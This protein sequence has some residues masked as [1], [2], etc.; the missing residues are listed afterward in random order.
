MSKWNDP[1]YEDDWKYDIQTWDAIKGED[2]E[3][4]CE[5]CSSSLCGESTCP[6]CGYPINYPDDEE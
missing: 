4:Y 1:L 2:G 6:E 5:G 3:Y